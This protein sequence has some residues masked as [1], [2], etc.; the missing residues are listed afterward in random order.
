[1]TL[2]IVF[3]W[4]TSY[5]LEPRIV[6]PILNDPLS[7]ILHAV[8]LHAVPTYLDILPLYLALF[9]IFPVI[10]VGLHLNRGLTIAVSAGLWIVANAVP[11]LNL[12][13]WMNNGH[14]YFNPLAWQFLFTIGAFLAMA[15]TEHGG[16]LPRWRIAAWL[17]AAFLVFALLQTVPWTDW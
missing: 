12:P 2:G 6:R 5:N 7:G 13:N 1:A 3:V 8:A 17:S 16:E 14:W 15:A 9:A 10:Y 11:T 4:T